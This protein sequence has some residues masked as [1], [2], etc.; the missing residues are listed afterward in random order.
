MNIKSKKKDKKHYNRRKLHL[1]SSSTERQPPN[2]NL[3]TK[4]RKKKTNPSPATDRRP[5]TRPIIAPVPP[6][7]PLRPRYDGAQ[8]MTAQEPR[9]TEYSTGDAW[10][11]GAA[12]GLPG[13]SWKTKGR[14]SACIWRRAGVAGRRGRGPGA[15]ML[16]GRSRGERADGSNR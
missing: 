6:S 15:G 10:S 11:N 12:A 4:K 5:K 14:N 16:S 9:A 2:P 1:S 7:R 8:Y 13:A 3:K